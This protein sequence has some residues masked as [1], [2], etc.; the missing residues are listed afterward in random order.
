MI[1]VPIW[2]FK[3]RNSFSSEYI[4]SPKLQIAPLKT[5]YSVGSLTSRRYNYPD[6]LHH[7]MLTE[8]DSER[9]WF[10]R[11]APLNF[12]DFIRPNGSNELQLLPS[13]FKI[14]GKKV[15]FNWWPVGTRMSEEDSLGP[16]GSDE[17]P[18]GI[19]LVP[20]HPTLCLD[21]GRSGWHHLRCVSGSVELQD[22]SFAVV[23]GLRLGLQW[24][25][26]DAC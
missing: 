6:L 24:R 15:G 1:F 4:S 11:A 12:T 25:S 19:R 22:S 23:V 10:N 21:R 14:M 18:P 16:V 2:C 20:V 13:Q 26:A 7:G 17:E 5:G 9:N 3:L 8:D